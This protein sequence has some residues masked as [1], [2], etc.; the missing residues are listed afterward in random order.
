MKNYSIFCDD[1]E[2]WSYFS[3]V[4]PFNS[5]RSALEHVRGMTSQAAR[6]EVWCEGILVG[7]LYR[8]DHPR[9]SEEA[10]VVAQARR[11]FLLAD[12]GRRLPSPGLLRSA[13]LS[14]AEP[15]DIGNSRHPQEGEQ[16]SPLFAVPLAERPALQPKVTHS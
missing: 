12:R 7:R 13:T 6:V 4:R 14:R 8:R 11:E 2:G 5:D 1:A 10:K 3:E 15:A 16:A 9:A